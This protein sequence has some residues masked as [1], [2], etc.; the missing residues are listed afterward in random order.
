MLSLP[1]V[2]C[3]SIPQKGSNYLEQEQQLLLKKITA[4]CTAPCERILKIPGFSNI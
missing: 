3:I 2:T 1:I 4:T